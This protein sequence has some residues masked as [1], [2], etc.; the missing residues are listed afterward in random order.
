MNKNTIME[1]PALFPDVPSYQIVFDKQRST[2]EKENLPEKEQKLLEDLHVQIQ[3][4]PEKSIDALVELYR[5]QPQVPEI[6]NLLT[7]G[8]LRL[9]KRAESEALIEKT[10]HDF[11]NY[12][13]AKINFADQCLR[14]NKIDQIPKIFG[15]VF[16]LNALYPDQK[17][18]HFAEFRGF[19]V[20]MGFYYCE[21]NQKEKA[22]ECYQLAFQV[23]PLH[24]SV[25]ALEQRLSK[26]SF[27]KK[28]LHTL[29]KLARI[30]KNP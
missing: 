9:K 19:Q 12:L 28:C 26:T 17:K 23:D 27:L 7:Y 2:R 29:Q 13:I 30:S 3:E 11:P 20:V 21:T 15:N 22:E 6:A 18:F 5:R 24:P 8:Y 25:S 14:L 1:I 4:N 10:Y 16:E